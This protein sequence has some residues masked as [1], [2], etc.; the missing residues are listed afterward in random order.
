MYI[1][2]T[3][4]A[5][6]FGGK[7]KIEATGADA[8]FKRLPFHCCALSLQP[9]ENPYVDPKTGVVYE[10]TNIIPW[11]KKHK[12]VDPI[13][14]E[15][16]LIKDLVRLT[17]TKSGSDYICPLTQKT[18]TEN[19]HIVAV[20]TSGYVYA[21]DAIERL[22]IKCKNWTD[23]MTGDPFT[24]KD[25]IEIQNPLN[26]EKRNMSSFFHVKNRLKLDPTA[27][28]S[29]IKSLNPGLARALASMNAASSATMTD[30]TAS[31]FSSSQSSSEP[32]PSTGKIAAHFSSG[33][34]SS[35]FTSTAM[36]PVTKNIAALVSEHHMLISL[37]PKPAKSYV[38]IV[39]NKGNLNMELFSGLCPLTCYNF[40]NLARN[41][42]YND[43][44]FH[45]LIKG[46]MLQGGDPTGTG[47][48]GESIFTDYDAKG[49]TFPDE[50]RGSLKHSDRGVLSMANKGKDTNTSQF[51]ILFQKAAHLDG[52]HT[53]FG[54][55]VD[56]LDVLDD[57]EVMSVDSKDSPTSPLVIKTVLVIQDCFQDEAAKL[58]AKDTK[59]RE[60][61]RY[62]KPEDRINSKTGT[63]ADETV[64]KYLQQKSGALKRGPE[65]SQPEGVVD[66]SFEVDRKK[67]SK[68][69][70]SGFGNFS[71]W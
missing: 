33:A 12:N 66:D 42:Y 46:F 36:A 11:L 17:F 47:R 56:G 34:G 51:F 31:I 8:G 67:K 70:Q 45:R 41:G 1:T 62:K 13:T 26:L 53:V 59:K 37:I 25:L 39:T 20:K 58:A 27:E 63:L 49:K 35:S 50:I 19:S 60:A 23:L 71:G 3:E 9:F 54:K 22:N 28:S 48:G 65:V 16:L 52:K 21:Y 32:S 68:V 64:G 2:A 40:I 14:G 43:V 7:K 38:S 44:K 24:R 30:A 6:E 5:T 18:F 4:W 61:E 10:L 55:V 57:I 15:P 69:G 29:A